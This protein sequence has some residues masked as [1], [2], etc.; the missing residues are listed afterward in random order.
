MTTFIRRTEYTITTSEKEPSSGRA[1]TQSL[2][3]RT[4]HNPNVDL[5]VV[6]GVEAV[7]RVV[8]YLV[9]PSFSLLIDARVHPEVVLVGVRVVHYIYVDMDIVEQV[10]VACV[11]QEPFNFIIVWLPLQCERLNEV[12]GGRMLPYH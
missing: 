6:K 3:G 11:H 9:S 12:K 8:V 2:A 10:R 4:L 7:R 1:G 5:P